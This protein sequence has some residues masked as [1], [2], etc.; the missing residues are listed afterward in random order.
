MDVHELNYTR[1]ESAAAA[2]VVEASSRCQDTAVSFRASEPDDIQGARKARQSP[3]LKHGTDEKGVPYV[4]QLL[5]DERKRITR[6]VQ[7]K[8][9]LGN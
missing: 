1:D 5:E 8:K 2:P 3:S 7:S 4:T 9:K 6:E